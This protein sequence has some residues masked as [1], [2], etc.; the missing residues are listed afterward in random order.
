MVGI[1]AIRRLRQR[2]SKARGVE[3]WPIEGVRQGEAVATKLADWRLGRMEC[4]SVLQDASR[5][6]C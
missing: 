4:L 2:K 5:I 1:A 3:G 6:R